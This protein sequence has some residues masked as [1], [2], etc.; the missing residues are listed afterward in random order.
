MDAYAW[1]SGRTNDVGGLQDDRFGERALPVM[2][3]VFVLGAG[4]SRAVSAV[5]PLMRD[6]GVVA[7]KALD[8]FPLPSRRPRAE[9][10]IETW[11]S[12]AREPQPF[13]TAESNLLNRAAAERVTA[14]I[15]DCVVAAQ[16][17]LER[18]EVP[19]WLDD[20]ITSWHGQRVD[21]ITLNWDTI[22]EATVQALRLWS[23]TNDPGSL[24]TSA[25]RSA[26]LLAGVPRTALAEVSVGLPS[27]SFHLWKLHG[28]IDWYWS[29]GDRYG[30]TVVRRPW[31]LGPSVG[32]FTAIATKSP[33]FAAPTATK[34][35]YYENQ[36]IRY[37]WRRA[38]QAL[39]DADEII[40][41]GYSLPPSDLAVRALLAGTGATSAVV[42]DICPNPVVERLQGLL[43]PRV[44]VKTEP[45]IATATARFADDQAGHAAMLVREAS[46]ASDIPVLL[47]LSN[48]RYA[49]AT[50]VTESERGFLVSSNAW[51][52][53]IDIATAASAPR[54]LTTRELAEALGDG[55]LLRVVD[56]DGEPRLVYGV[57][58]VGR[59]TGQSTRWVQLRAQL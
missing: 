14:A 52:E 28:S 46:A 2:R 45:D 7:A 1:N 23:L 15:R 25:V 33:F 56:P 41:L 13:L 57:T 18:G 39:E 58:V 53:S 11:L 51:A 59:E 55:Q 6:L 32:D 31:E 26:D 22:V 19:A 29:E 38:R 17:E 43:G 21:V 36:V 9:D 42:I 35:A 48:A 8:G 12:F 16:H 27:T 34:G 37:V 49:G 47:A 40:L 20:L 50:S 44:A 3:R 54:A 30:E 4:F 10:D 24:E 5:M